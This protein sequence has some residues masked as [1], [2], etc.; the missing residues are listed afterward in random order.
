MTELQILKS[1]PLLLTP[2]RDKNNKVALHKQRPLNSS[3]WRPD[4][5]VRNVLTLHD[6][7]T[8][9]CR[10]GSTKIQTGW[11]ANSSLNRNWCRFCSTRTAMPCKIGGSVYTTQPFHLT[12]H[13]HLPWF[14]RCFHKIP[15]APIINL[16]HPS[17]PS[18]GHRAH[19][20]QLTDC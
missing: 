7:P 12:F 9:I 13:I 19:C 11:C 15:Q 16:K 2:Q 10:L 20:E 17:L 4:Q 8:T 18:T 1:K 5:N 6:S 14:N 3:W